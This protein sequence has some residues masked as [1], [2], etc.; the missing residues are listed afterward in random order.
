VEISAAEFRHQGF[1]L[2]MAKNRNPGPHAPGGDSGVPAAPLLS[3]PP[4]SEPGWVPF[5]LQVPDG[6]P[7]SEVEVRTGEK[8]VVRLTLPP[9]SGLNLGVRA[10]LSSLGVGE[11]SLVPVS[12]GPSGRQIEG[13]AFLLRLRPARA[14]PEEA[15]TFA[16]PGPAGAVPA[17]GLVTAFPPGAH[18]DGGARRF[19]V[20]APGAIRYAIPAGASVIQ[21]NFGIHPG[22]YGPENA[23]PTDGIRFQIRLLSGSGEGAVLFDRVLMPSIRPDDR[24]DQAFEVTLPGLTGTPARIELWTDEG[25]LGSMSS[26]WSYWKGVS[27]R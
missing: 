4:V 24:G 8:V 6:P 20:H 11:H 3:G 1:R 13:P 7:A 25:P 9:T 19:D 15:T 21:G 16:V 2:L 10:D 27:F 17:D 23:A 22:A 5:T 18:D 14:T 26:D 12:R